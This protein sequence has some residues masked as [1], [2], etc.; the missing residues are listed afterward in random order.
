M[1]SEL[2]Q[3]D[4]Q[5]GIDVGF[6]CPNHTA[7]Q[8]YKVVMYIINLKLSTSGNTGALKQPKSNSAEQL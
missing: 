7:T 3:N 1:L 8:G 4:D 5:Q 6:T 2:P